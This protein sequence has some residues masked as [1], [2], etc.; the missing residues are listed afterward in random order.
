[1]F[2][3]ITL[4]FLALFISVN[5]KAS[6]VLANEYKVTKINQRVFVITQ[7]W[8]EKFK[9]NMGVVIGDDGLLLINTM[10]L[11]DVKKLELEL[12]RLA[13]KPVK[14][15]INSNWDTY[16]VQANEYFAQ[17]GAI[18]IAQ[19]DNQFWPVH[20]QLLFKNQFSLRLGGEDVIAYKTKAHSF[21]HVNVHLPSANVIFMAD[22]YRNDWMT[23]AGPYGLEGHL[24]GIESAVV[25]SDENTIIVP[26]NT[27]NKPLSNLA[28]LKK[29]KYIR[30]TL[31]NMVTSLREQGLS[32]KEV[33]EHNDVKQ[34]FKKHYPD[35]EFSAKS[36]VLKLINSELKSP[37]YLSPSQIQKYEGK[38]QSKSGEQIEL[39]YDGKY[40]V[41]KSQNR[42]ITTLLPE[43]IN[44]FSFVTGTGGESFSFE[45]ESDTQVS[46]LIPKLGD[47]YFGRLIPSGKWV[48]M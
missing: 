34:F 7:T 19:E 6:D 33:F 39:K 40:F 12:R 35:R 44:A 11:R 30:M 23:V 15:V 22:S 16:N 31:K 38:Y 46:Y 47:S 43:S 10:M 21:G 29:E 42:F 37:F 9:A 48:K 24:Q 4:L 20:R 1:M 18:I 36:N 5:V 32:D 27:F 14:Y 13:D 8:S 26:G 28:D 25:R 41:A 45:L 3:R 2:R 17:K